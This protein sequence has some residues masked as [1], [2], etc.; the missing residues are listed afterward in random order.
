MISGLIYLLGEVPT[1]AER[2]VT[3]WVF[4]DGIFLTP[5]HRHHRSGS[6]NNIGDEGCT[7]LKP[8]LQSVSLLETLDLR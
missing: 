6:W 7:A 1:L 4:L 5:H 2:R 8:A 3:F